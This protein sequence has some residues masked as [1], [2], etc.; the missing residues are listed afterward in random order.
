MSVV[1]ENAE[2]EEAEEL[3]V[4]TERY[5]QD[6][7]QALSGTG[8]SSTD[9]SFTLTSNPGPGAQMNSFPSPILPLSI[10]SLSLLG[11]VLF[12]EVPEPVEEVR[13]LLT[14]GLERGTP[15]QNFN[16]SLKEENHR[17]RHEL[18]HINADGTSVVRRLESEL[19][20]RFFLVLNDKKAKIHSLQENT[21]HLQE[22]SMEGTLRS[23]SPLDDSLNYITDMVP[24]RKR[25][26]RHLQ[27]PDTVAKRPTPEPAQKQTY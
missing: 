17:L 3:E 12:C 7:Q 25:H 2:R 14:H 1:S 10:P 16:H 27:P 22:T 20:S 6:L 21:T 19:Y 11:S 13:V 8:T 4:Q 24:C 26:F 23:R 15:L 18:Q 9:Y 5:I